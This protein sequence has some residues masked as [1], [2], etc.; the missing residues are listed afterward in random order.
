VRTPFWTSAVNIFLGLILTSLAAAQAGNS[1][2]Q[3]PASVAP[4]L[5]SIVSRMEQAQSE[6][7][8]SIRAYVVTRDYQLFKEGE[9]QPQSTVIAE[10]SFVPPGTKKYEIQQASGSG[11]GEK[12]V[13]KVLS[14]E[15][16]MAKDNGEHDLS[17]KNYEF[18]YVGMEGLDGA[19]CYVLHLHPKRDDKNLIEGL[20]WIDASTYMPRRI[21]G[22]PAKNPSW[23][24]KNLRVEMDYASVAG[25]WLPIGSRAEADV[26]IFGK[27]T[28]VGRDVQYQTSEAVAKVNAPPRLRSGRARRPSPAAAG[29]F[30]PE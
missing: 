26:R 12:L 21:V 1:A 16:E 20:A 25:M 14:H 4:E 11:Q 23:W 8:A 19:R 17:R 13:R 6:N 30:I 28:F 18:A 5:S 10:V 29:V 15:Q 3:P 7:R 9:R 2:P 27:H 22:T 24:V